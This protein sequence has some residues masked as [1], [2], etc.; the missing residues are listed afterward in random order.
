MIARTRTI[1]LASALAVLA[2]VV[3]IGALVWLRPDLLPAALRA[4][5]PLVPLR[6]ADTAFEGSAPIYVAIE[7]GYFRDEGLDVSMTQTQAGWQNLKLLFE[8]QADLAMVADLPIAYTL[9]DR[10]KYT[11]ADYAPFVILANTLFN[12]GLSEALGM[13]DRGVLAPKDLEG[14]TVAV[15]R[16][17]TTDFFFDVFAKTHGLDESRIKVIDLPTRKHLAALESGEVDAAFSFRGDTLE[18]KRVL[19]AR[20]QSLRTPISYST[21]WLVVALKAY[22]KEHPDELAAFLRALRRAIDHMGTDPAAAL[23]ATV[24][25]SGYPP[26]VVKELLADYQFAL[27][28]SESLFSVLADEMQWVN[29][30]LNKPAAGKSN[31]LDIV[32]TEPLR[33]AYPDAIKL[34]R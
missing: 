7:Q 9:V 17:T 8:G 14:R 27:S 20:A 12:Y 2:T 25:H 15:H 1:G 19:G 21:A 18:Q 30:T 11:N 6:L 26:E 33:R 3:V 24:K 16:G 5:R 28:L 31:L 29:G 4:P 22:S 23:Q 32:D 13:R 34:I 10:H